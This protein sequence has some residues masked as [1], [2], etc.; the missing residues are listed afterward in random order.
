MALGTRVTVYIRAVELASLLIDI[1]PKKDQ[2]FESILH[3][4]SHGAAA[5][6]GVL[7]RIRT[8]Y[9]QTEKGPVSTED[10][11]WKVGSVLWILASERLPQS[12]SQSLKHR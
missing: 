8:T 7:H 9:M 12:S 5:I 4:L 6:N 10:N 1:V 2:D 11:L 3:S